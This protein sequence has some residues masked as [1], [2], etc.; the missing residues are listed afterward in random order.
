[1]PAPA[2]AP[3]VTVHHFVAHV[4]HHRLFCRAHPPPKRHATEKSPTFRDHHFV[5]HVSHHMLFCRAHPLRKRHATE[6]A[7]TK[8]VRSGLP[9][10]VSS[11]D[12]IDAISSRHG[13]P[14]HSF[15]GSRCCLPEKVYDRAATQ[16]GLALF[17]QRVMLRSER[18][19]VE[20]APHGQVAYTEAHG[21]EC[22][23]PRPRQHR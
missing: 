17:S 20:T 1:M 9:A 3:P 23:K 14:C 16:E 6:K 15:I 21:I 22:R 8:G 4:S 13:A 19:A 7:P 2:A 12:P 11:D 18:S 5:A 10:W